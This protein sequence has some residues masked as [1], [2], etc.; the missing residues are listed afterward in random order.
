MF[1]YMHV[2]VYSCVYIH[3]VY[4]CVHILESTHYFS[5]RFQKK[6]LTALSPVKESRR[7]T[8]TVHSG[9]LFEYS[10]CA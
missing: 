10:A 4:V 9:K 3:C 1:V 6:P 5:G 2:C 8:G 7:H